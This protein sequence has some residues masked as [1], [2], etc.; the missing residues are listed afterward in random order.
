MINLS[1]IYL[2]SLQANLK[3]RELSCQTYGAILECVVHAKCL[4]STK[5][6]TGTDYF[7]SILLRQLHYAATTVMHAI[8]FFR[9][10]VKTF[11]F[12]VV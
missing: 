10:M 3:K 6:S 11:L 7:M 4:Y 9:R 5:F 8:L 12:R 2:L 1:M